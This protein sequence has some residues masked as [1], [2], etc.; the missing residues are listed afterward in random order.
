MAIQVNT[1]FNV[2][3]R[4]AGCGYRLAGMGAHHNQTTTACFSQAAYC[5]VM[6]G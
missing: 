1:G 3:L 5:S 4:V 2:Q 6:I